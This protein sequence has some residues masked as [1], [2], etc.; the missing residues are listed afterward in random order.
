MEDIEGQVRGLADPPQPSLDQLRAAAARLTGGHP[1]AG[2]PLS[3]A[4]E[5]R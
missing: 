2:D 4:L 5:V 3:Y 1:D